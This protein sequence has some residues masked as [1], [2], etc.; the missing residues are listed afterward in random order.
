LVT[1]RRPSTEAKQRVNAQGNEDASARDGMRTST[2][3]NNRE[4]TRA[5]VRASVRDGARVSGRI[6]NSESTRASDT[7]RVVRGAAATENTSAPTRRSVRA[8]QN[9]PRRLWPKVLVLSMVGVLVLV[10][11]LF[12]WLRWFGVDDAK[13]MQGTW[14]AS[15]LG[16]AVE[17][18]GS[19]IKITEDVAYSYTLDATAK[20]FALSFGE[21]AGG[22]HY[23]FSPDRQTLVFIDGKGGGV[24][25]FFEDISWSW[26]AWLAGVQSRGYAVPADE[27]AV[28]LTREGATVADTSDTNAG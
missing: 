2:R 26:E 23:W 19:T 8:Q 14:Y 15:S 12:S 5:N 20:T 13:D 17:I 10:I 9:K 16:V 25:E 1:K 11:A 3:A 28:V 6:N 21:Y 4:G 24:N 27:N 7:A 18:D 22:G